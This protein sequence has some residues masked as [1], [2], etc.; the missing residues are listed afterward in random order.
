MRRTTLFV[1]AAVL[2]VAGCA[3]SGASKAGAGVLTVGMPNGPM[4]ENHNPYLPTSAASSLGYRYVIYEPLVQTN[5]VRPT[6]KGTPW[7][8]TAWEWAPDYRKVIFTPRENVKW[9]DGKP[10]TPADVAFSFTLLKKFPA[11]DVH[12]LPIDTVTVV[13]GKVE[14]TFTRAQFINELKVLQTMVVPEH[15]WAAVPDPT[16]YVNPDPVGTG[17]Y[18]LKTFTP[19]TTTVVRRDAY[20]Q[21]LPKVPEIQYTSYNDNSAQTTALAS[22][23]SQWSYVFM[24]NYKTLYVDKDPANNKLWFPSGLGIHGLWINHTVAPFDNVALR[25]AMNDVI[26]RDAIFLRGEAGLFPK[27]ESPTGLPRPAGDPFLAP[28]Y[29]DAKHE[30]DVPKA[31]ERLAA[32]GFKLEGGVLKDPSGKAVTIELT[33]PAGWSDYLTDLDIIKNDLKQIGIEATVRTQTADAWT[34]DFSNGKFQGS[35]R[36]TDTGGTPYDIYTDVMNGNQLR[37]VGEAAGGNQGRYNNPEATKALEAYESATDDATRKASLAVLQKIM[38]E[39]VPMIP[40]SAAPIGA[41]Y[42]TKHWTGWPSEAD[43]YAPPQA[44]LP[45]AIQIVMRLSPTS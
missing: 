16:T 17:P 41:E 45:N 21:E 15:V 27:L 24:P 25:Q 10:M 38:A 40:T 19:Q 20:W 5:P 44:T 39:Q 26:D 12:S 9:S 42:T 43:P 23:T 14:V 30:V 28:E 22:G 7:L 13:D 35:M 33:N 36:W 31:K 8:A 1:L 2:A 37:P 3:P 29:V 32:A 34:T 4:T 6:D 18:K 11:L